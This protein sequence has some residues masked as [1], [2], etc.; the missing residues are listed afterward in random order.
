MSNQLRVFSSFDAHTVRD[1]P[2]H[3]HVWST[4]ASFLLPRIGQPI[5][6][7]PNIDMCYF[8]THYSRLILATGWIE[9][10]TCAVETTRPEQSNVRCGKRCKRYSHW[11]PSSGASWWVFDDFSHP[12]PISL[13][14]QTLS[15]CSACRGFCPFTPG[16][17]FSPVSH[18][19]SLTESGTI[20]C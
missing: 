12:S 3:W 2:Q 6:A 18:I 19:Y 9:L 16:V 13:P 17:C 14:A 4:Q 10:Y 5:S 1:A 8:L 15:S 11:R 20:A 7:W